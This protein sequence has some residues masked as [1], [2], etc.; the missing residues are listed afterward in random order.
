M[1]GLNGRKTK[2]ATGGIKAAGSRVD[3]TLGRSVKKGQEDKLII[4]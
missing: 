4:Y 3:V 2:L 1:A